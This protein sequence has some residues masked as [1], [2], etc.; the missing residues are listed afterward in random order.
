[1]DSTA[2]RATIRP[3]PVDRNQRK[4]VSVSESKKLEYVLKVIVM[5]QNGLL[6]AEEALSEITEIVCS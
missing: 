2:K 4:E 1:M 6:G 5:K 3:M